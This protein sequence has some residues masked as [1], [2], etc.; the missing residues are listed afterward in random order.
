VTAARRAA[1]ALWLACTGCA[2][3]TVTRV[4]DGREFEGRAISVEAYAAYA[5]AELFRAQGDRKQALRFLEQAL[6]MDP[7]S[8]E[9]FARHGELLCEGAA[10]TKALA[11]FERA[12]DLD[13]RYA[14][15]FL[16]RARCLARSGRSREALADAEHAAFLDPLSLDT[17]RE[18]ARL[19]FAT[20]RA[21]DGWLWL[22]A[23]ILLEPSSRGPRALLLEAA[24]REHDADRA[25]RARH[26]LGASTPSGLRPAAPAAPR[27]VAAAPLS[28]LEQAER[29]LAADPEDTDAWARGLAAADLIGDEDRFRRILGELGESP[30]PLSPASFA[31]LTE[32]LARRCGDD[33]ARALT[34]A[35]DPA[36]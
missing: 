7:Q 12:L 16:G 2:P 20:G 25:A 4:V 3:G 33:A 17:T 28:A 15:A 11:R 19:L 10:S 6:D 36:R 27:S 26:F 34:R 32:L 13:P 24:E 1:L 9:L 22:E 23:R 18:V 8:P 31:L 21:Q 5:K 29:R 30:L 35:A 14:P